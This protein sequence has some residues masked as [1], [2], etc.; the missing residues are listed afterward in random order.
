M[1]VPPGLAAWWWVGTTAAA[2]AWTGTA[3]AADP[4]SIEWDAPSACPGDV[5]VRA[6]LHRWLELTPEGM[7]AAAVEAH[8]HVRPAPDGWQ[9]ELTLVSPGGRQ[10]ERL[11]AARCETIVELVALKVA[12]AANP[13]AVVQGLS[14]ARPPAEPK[15][16]IYGARAVFG[17]GAGVLPGTAVGLGVVGSVEG[18]AWRVELGG[19]LWFPRPSVYPEL[20]N[21]GA[22]VSLVAGEARGCLLPAIGSVVLPICGGVEVGMMRASGFGAALTRTSDQLWAALVFGPALQWHLVGPL[23]LWLEGE[24]LLAL[25]RPEFHFRNLSLLYKPEPAAAQAWSGLELRFD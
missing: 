3:Q 15:S 12:L 9:L 7:Q 2:F 23:S 22:D 20:P 25:N 8:A 11:V 1:R 17:V 13:T 18:P 6:A 24:A 16:L 19:Q 21:V 4:L 5:A 10:E 14:A